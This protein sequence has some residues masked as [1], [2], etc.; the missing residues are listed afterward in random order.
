MDWFNFPD[1]KIFEPNGASYTVRTSSALLTNDAYQIHVL[2]QY[3]YTTIFG[4][5]ITIKPKL[6][7][8]RLLSQHPMRGD[9]ITFD[10]TME[11][12]HLAA[13]EEVFYIF[14]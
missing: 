11:E 1:K 12:K 13:V 2:G 5:F 6:T 4:Q 3:G 8:G 9:T 14:Q 7:N 10:I